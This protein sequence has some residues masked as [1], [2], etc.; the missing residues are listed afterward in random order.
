MAQLSP[1]PSDEHRQGREGRG[2]LTDIAMGQR[3]RVSLLEN[4]NNAKN[5]NRRLPVSSH[6][7]PDNITPHLPERCNPKHPF[8][9]P[10]QDSFIH[11]SYFHICKL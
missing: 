4:T 2:S 6:N 3:L 8:P 9:F 11:S 10:P 1:Q 7:P 5:I